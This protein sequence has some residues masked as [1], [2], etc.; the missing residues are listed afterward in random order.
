MTGTL[1]EITAESTSRFVQV[2][3]HRIHLHDT[4]ARTA[5]AASRPPLVLL[6][7]GGPGASGWSNFSQNVPGLAEHFRVIVLDQPGYGRSDKPIVQ[8]GVW[9]FNAYILSGVLDALEIPSV[10]LVGNSLGGGTSLRMALDYPDRV[11]RLI[12]MGPAGGTLNIF[13]SDPSEGLKVLFGFYAPPGP[14]IEKMQHL[15]DVMTYD[16]SNVPPGVLEQRYAAATAPDAVEYVT[17]LFGTFGARGAGVPEELWRDVH[18]I[19]H[20]TLLT[21]GRDDRVLPL[22]GAF[23]MLKRMP[24]ARLHVFP[25]CGHWAQL[26]HQAEF[27][28]LTVSFL[29]GP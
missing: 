12:L 23:F 8:D 1:A 10:H 17:R 22:D 4:G 28:A 29:T 6:H 16:S 11:D 25:R 26:E 20:K 19:P 24:D 13:S 3:E 14:S 21:W 18:R 5:E 7:G 27:D 15:I 2:D 9:T